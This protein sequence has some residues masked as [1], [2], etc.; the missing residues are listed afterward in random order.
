MCTSCILILLKK[1]SKKTIFLYGEYKAIPQDVLM[2][3]LSHITS[4]LSIFERAK[5]KR[6]NR[7]YLKWS[8]FVLL[9]LDK[10]SLISISIP[11][12]YKVSLV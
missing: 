10:T 1:T 7:I 12:I 6:P 2:V 3:T 11:N 8:K 5:L 4:F 9:K